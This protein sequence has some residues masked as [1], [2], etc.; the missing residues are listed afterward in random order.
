MC[1]TGQMFLD[2]EL[3]IAWF[4][5]LPEIFLLYL[6]VVEWTATETMV[7]N[8]S[9]PF[10]RV[11]PDPPQTDRLNDV[12]TFNVETSLWT[13]IGGSKTKLVA[14]TYGTIG[15]A[16]AANVPGA[17]NWQCTALDY[18]RSRMYIFGGWGMPRSG[19]GKNLW[20]N[21]VKLG[22]D[23]DTRVPRCFERSM[24]IRHKYRNVGLDWRLGP[25]WGIK[26][27][28]WD[29]G[30]RRCYESSWRASLVSLDS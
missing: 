16:A 27:L 23:C 7:I 22:P 24:G 8:L 6:V 29:Q 19:W 3:R 14:S 2:H 1:P 26:S 5:I 18:K 28:F 25:S 11:I 20:S 10:K 9:W 4:I 30:H 17:R 13:W 15:I 12:W 21:F